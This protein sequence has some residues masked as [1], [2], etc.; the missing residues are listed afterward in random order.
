ME[1]PPARASQRGKVIA[2]VDY[3]APDGAT[4]QRDWQAVVE[5]WWRTEQARR[6]AAWRRQAWRV[7]R[8]AALL[9]TVGYWGL[10]WLGTGLFCGVWNPVAWGSV[11]APKAWGMAVGLW[12]LLLGALAWA[13]HGHWRS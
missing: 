2:L 12:A 1:R 7:W 8:L 10:Q 5:A 9:W 13:E 3:L 4:P 11:W 6:R